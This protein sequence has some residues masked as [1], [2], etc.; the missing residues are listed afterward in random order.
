MSKQ[1]PP[2]Q[3]PQQTV[4]VAGHQSQ[5]LP[6]LVNCFCFPGLGQLIQ[7]RLLAAIV[8]WCLHLLGALSIFV[9]IGIILWPII[10]IACVIDA[11]R[12]N[13]A[14]AQLSRGRGTSP[15]VKVLAAVLAIVIFVPLVSVIIASI[16][17]PPTQIADSRSA[18]PSV[19][20]VPNPVGSA[21]S[22]LEQ[23]EAEAIEPT[24]VTEAEAPAQTS[25]S[26]ASRTEGARIAPAK[27][28]SPKTT[29]REDT[30]PP[31]A[32]K[33]SPKLIIED[34]RFTTEYGFAKVAGRVTNNSSAS[35]ENVTAVVSFLTSDGGFVKTSEAIIS[36]NPILPG[37]TSPFEVADTANP[38]IERASLAFKTLL[39][40]SLSAMSREDF[41]KPS[42]EEIAAKRRAEEEA[43][44][45][46]AE[47]EARKA[48][49]IEAA[50]WKTWTTAD[51]KYKVRAKF[52][53]F[54]L[55]TVT[56]EKEDGTTVDVK[57]DILC[58]EDQDFVKGRKWT[59]TT[60]E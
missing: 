44:R 33:P 46:R 52:V 17:S 5:A 22:D 26:G 58:P 49:A 25:D 45:A 36:Y 60:K 1:Q 37:Q 4:I 51:G 40:G 20:P 54:A 9:G 12:Y 11:A 50:K 16:G 38:A 59:K 47:E 48:A 39:G 19:A 31:P 55:G 8:W 32:A 41:N 2:Q 21:D 23:P 53:T 56:L 10:W 57:L 29:P 18:S 7:V 28:E 42:P 14:A 15:V 34:W 27:A 6:A 24:N 43:A 35:L 30:S 13:P 3:P